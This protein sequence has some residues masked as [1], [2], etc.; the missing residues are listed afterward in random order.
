MKI[1][2][3]LKD[4]NFCTGC[5]LLSFVETIP[6]RMSGYYGC[7]KYEIHDFPEDEE[8]IVRPAKCIEENGL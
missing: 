8:N 5:P 7:S 1:E 2:I 4:V 6:G 3:Q